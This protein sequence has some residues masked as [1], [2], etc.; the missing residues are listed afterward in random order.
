MKKLLGLESLSG[1][2]YSITEIPV[3]L[4]REIVVEMGGAT[5]LRWQPL[6]TALP[7]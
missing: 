6:E 5:A 4:I 7:A 1:I 2:V 3:D